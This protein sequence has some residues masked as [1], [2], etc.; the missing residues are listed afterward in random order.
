MCSKTVGRKWHCNQILDRTFMFLRNF[1]QCTVNVQSNKV[2]ATRTRDQHK[3]VLARFTCRTKTAHAYMIASQAD[4]PVLYLVLPGSY[5]FLDEM[6]MFFC[7][8]RQDLTDRS[9][10]R[11]IEQSF[12][13]YSYASLTGV[14]SFL[15]GSA[16]EIAKVIKKIMQ[17]T[18]L[19]KVV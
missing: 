14:C 19:S 10:L 17:Q 6:I 2:I 5:L 18:K 1:Y 16:H 11:W 8:E 15:R 9:A 13:F 3:G 7:A 4:W 12:L